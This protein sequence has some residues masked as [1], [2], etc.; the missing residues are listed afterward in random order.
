MAFLDLTGLTYYTTKLK[1]WVQNLISNLQPDGVTI[2]NTSGKMVAVDVQLGEGDLANAT[3]RGWI[4]DRKQP[5]VN[6]KLNS[7]PDNALTITDFNLL[8]EPGVYHIR[9]ESE[10]VLNGPTN[11]S[12]AYVDGILIVRCVGSAG[13]ISD[14]FRVVQIIIPTISVL[15]GTVFVRNL[16]GASPFFTFVSATN[17]TFL[18]NSNNSI[19]DGLAVNGNKLT[20]PE[21]TGATSSVAGTSGL[22]P[23]PDK[24]DHTRALLG[25]GDF[26]YPSAIALGSQTDTNLT[27]GWAYDASRPRWGNTT[28][29]VYVDDLNNV[30]IPGKYH[31]LI[32]LT[33]TANV[34]YNY[35][36]AG[37]AGPDDS[38]PLGL[39]TAIMDV[40][41]VLTDGY[42]SSTA[43]ILQRMHLTNAVDVVTQD[44]IW[45]RRLNWT[46]ASGVIASTDWYAI[47]R[48]GE[49]I[50]GP[51]AYVLNRNITKG[52]EPAN[53]YDML[54]FC[55]EDLFSK[56]QSIGNMLAVLQY[57]HTSN[58]QGMQLRSYKNE[59]GS[60]EC[61]GFDIG[62]SGAN[63][64]MRMTDSPAADSNDK[65]IATTE[66]VRSLVQS[67][68][69]S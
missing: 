36:R 43:R 14:S 37:S 11:I 19:G 50:L 25:N 5:T 33:K 2:K 10:D 32:S 45:E 21:M 63:K 9:W 67:M 20:V 23:A 49:S 18:V 17:W 44:S 52:A 41:K 61:V 1:T 8:Y 56:N 24:N 59:E 30:I 12:S 46:A 69:N 31:V 42:I 4:T 13:N 26:G 60:L 53:N 62:Y 34:P 29:F 3:A 40:E 54:L 55:G 48:S 15:A 65:S 51:N 6:G 7:D 39:V 22:V 27:R 47:T 28:D 57:A 68:L 35:A 38:D 64:I 58:I 16:V 66:W